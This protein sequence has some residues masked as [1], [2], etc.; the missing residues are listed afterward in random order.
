[1]TEKNRENLV[2]RPP[3]VVVMGHVDH[4]KTS[5]LDYI[6]QSRV[7]LKEAGGITQHVGAYEIEYSPPAGTGVSKQRITFID[8]PGHEAFAKIRERGAKVADLAILVIAADEGIK[9]QTKEAL[10]YIEKEKLP[11]II[12]L[13]KIDLPQANPDK[14]KQELAE[15]GVFV[16][17]WGGKIPCLTVSAK[18]GQGIDELL[19]M[20]LLVAELEDLKADPSAE[21]E[22]VIIESSLDPNRGIVAT[23]IIL[24]GTLEPGKI[25]YTPSTKAKIKSLENFLGQRQTS[26]SFSSPAIITGWDKQPLAGEKFSAQPILSSTE[27]IEEKTNTIPLSSLNTDKK[28]FPLILK[29]DVIGSLEALETIVEQ[30][31]QGTELTP[32][33]IDKSV[34]PINLNDLKKA[35]TTNAV[36]IGFRSK[37]ESELGNYLRDRRITLFQSEIIYELMEKLRKYLEEQLKPAEDQLTGRLKVLAIFSQKDKKNRQI[38]GGQLFEGKVKKGQ[39]FFLVKANQPETEKTEAGKVLTIRKNKQEL[40]SAEAVMEIGLQVESSAEFSPEDILE[41]KA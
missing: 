22:G 35:E 41:F 23:A 14:V 10:S 18:T 32:L 33:I 25:I 26:L 34:G 17:G 9:P 28:T 38:I 3:V 21:P 5:L 39:R 29:A 37:L 11:F 8:T 6:R 16:E 15:L 2:T 20:I 1:M 31:F 4:G 36:V 30:I 12:A 40:D 7:A 19:E 13:N 24:N 27:K